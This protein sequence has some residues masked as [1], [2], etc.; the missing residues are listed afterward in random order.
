MPNAAER[1]YALSLMRAKPHR[2]LYEGGNGKQGSGKFYVD[3]TGDE[4]DGSP[5]LD[6]DD[7]KA[8][9]DAGLIERKWPDYDGA[10]LIRRATEGRTPAK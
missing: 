6:R 9:L 3:Y 4:P 10:Y 2:T 8:L 5:E 7:V 1:E